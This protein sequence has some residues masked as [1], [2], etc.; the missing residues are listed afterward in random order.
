MKSQSIRRNCH[1]HFQFHCQYWP[2]L[3]LLGVGVS[4]GVLV[5]FVAFMLAEKPTIAPNR[6]ET[7]RT[8]PK[9]CSVPK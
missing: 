4:V 1:C 7:T 6:S 8:L 9:S 5:H 2:W 3:V